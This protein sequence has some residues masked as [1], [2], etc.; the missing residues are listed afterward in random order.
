MNRVSKWLSFR[1]WE[2]HSLVLMVGGSVY[3]IIGLIFM[4]TS[5]MTSTR[6]QTLALALRHAPLH[7]WGFVFFSGG[8]LALL[9]SKW[10]SF[11]NSWGYMVLTGLA[12]GWSGM[13]LLGYILNGRFMMT[14]GYASVWALIAFM[15]WG[16]SGLVNPEKV[17]EVVENGDP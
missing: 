7:T 14:L 4:N 8:L 12:S 15:W 10:P 5:E 2:R 13:Y 17:L 16:I 6:E 11:N 1:P 3:M 9:S